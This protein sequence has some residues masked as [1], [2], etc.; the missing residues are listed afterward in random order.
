MVTNA[1][2]DETVSHPLDAADGSII[3]GVVQP[4]AD[5]RTSS[6]TGEDVVPVQFRYSPSTG[7]VYDMGG[8]KTGNDPS[9]I[10]TPVD[11]PPQPRPSPAPTPPA[12]EVP[13]DN[14]AVR[15]PPTTR[16]VTPPS[17]ASITVTHPI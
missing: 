1:P 17:D 9:F 7:D 15:L 11:H 13:V 3:H 6:Q 5:L 4:P 14:P 2:P 12:P 16:P 10:E 8:N